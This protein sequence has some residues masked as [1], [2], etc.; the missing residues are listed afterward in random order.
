MQ[1]W[2]LKRIGTHNNLD[3]LSHEKRPNVIFAYP[4]VKTLNYKNTVNTF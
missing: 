2:K 4:N 3:L 1:S